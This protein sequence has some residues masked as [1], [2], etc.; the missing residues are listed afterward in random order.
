MYIKSIHL[1]FF[2]QP[3]NRKIVEDL[4]YYNYLFNKKGK[5]Q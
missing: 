5:P 4:D 3:T 1:S 2:V